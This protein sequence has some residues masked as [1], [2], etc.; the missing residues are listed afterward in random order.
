[1]K[2]L[3]IKV[4]FLLALIIGF[5]ACEEEDNLQTEGLWELSTPTIVGPTNNASI[6]LDETKPNELITFNWTAATSSVGY[7]VTYAVLIVDTETKNYE[8]PI[9]EI[10]VNNGGKDLSA[11]ISYVDLD[12]ALSY[13]EYPANTL[14][15]VTFAVVAKSLSKS[16]IVESNL[17]VTRFMNEY[18]PQQLFLSGTG[19]EQGTNL[20]AAISFKRLNN[21]EGVASNKYEL[22]TSLTAGNSFEL[23]SEQSLPAHR[24]GGSDGNLQKNGNPITVEEDGTYRI[25]VDLDANIYSIFKIEKW[26]VVGSPIIN[27]WGGDEPLTYI[28]AGIWQATI[29]FVET[30]GF[31]FRA[32]GDWGYLLKRIK[33]TA[34]SLVMESQSASQGLSYE[35]IPSEI[36]GTMIVTLDLSSN[37]YTY[38]LE[39]APSTAEPLVT[40]ETLFL[41]VNNSMVE[42]LTKNEAVFK[43]SSY[44]P[45]QVTDEVTVNTM[46]DGTGE[47]YTIST[48]IGATDTPDQIK[49]SVNSDLTAGNEGIQVEKAQ[50]YSVSLDFANAKFNWTYYNIF[51][52]QWDE[53]NQKWDDRDEFLLTYVHPFTF[54]TTANLYANFDMKFFSPWDN[55]FGADDPS[56]LTGTM[57]NKGGSNFRNIKTDGSYNVTITVTNDFSTGTYDFEKQ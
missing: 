10:T 2:N 29:E 4:I 9:A 17:S 6:V 27:N 15:N 33:G 43:S 13:A 22:Y 1:M 35:D 12:L 14:V 52:Y 47:S 26:S 23:Y 19:T 55:E 7:G 8:N 3:Y 44:I 53:I 25:S 24:F 11:T 5:G 57:T 49:V 31:L 56:E 20:S 45:L 51:L 42:E 18:I 40:P 32:N 28:G 30:G 38:T 37:A 48:K 41:F 54:T 36:K 16:Q 39:K 21:S 50:A 46:A 34:N